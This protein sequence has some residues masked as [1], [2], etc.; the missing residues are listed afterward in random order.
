MAHCPDNFADY[1]HCRNACGGF[2]TGDFLGSNDPNYARMAGSSVLPVLALICSRG[3]G[4]VGERAG[5][6]RRDCR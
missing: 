5:G 4:G 6:S 2:P 3:A 1:D